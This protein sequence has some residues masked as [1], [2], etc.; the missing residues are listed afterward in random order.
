MSRSRRKC[1][2]QRFGELTTKRRESAAAAERRCCWRLQT[3]DDFCLAHA[4]KP[5]MIT[6][7]ASLNSNDNCIRGEDASLMEGFRRHGA[8]GVSA[9]RGLECKHCPEL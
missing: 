8:R 7:L 5:V 1:H 4:K 6:V 2:G 3:N 9:D